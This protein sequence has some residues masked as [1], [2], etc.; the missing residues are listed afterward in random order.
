MPSRQCCMP[1]WRDD[2]FGLDAPADAT[3]VGC[4]QIP[5]PRSFLRRRP[6]VGGP[7]KRSKF[8]RS[9]RS[10]WGV[11]HVDSTIARLLDGSPERRIAA[12]RAGHHAPRDL[13]H[14]ML[15][16]P[17]PGGA[18]IHGVLMGLHQERR[19]IRRGGQS[20]RAAYLGEIPVVLARP[21]H[22][23]AACGAVPFLVWRLCATLRALHGPSP[24]L[25]QAR[26]WPAVPGLLAMGPGSPREF[27]DDSKRPG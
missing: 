24:R 17:A 19:R 9:G 7:G 26:A 11:F 20:L 23:H 16:T 8:D 18:L 6:A 12:A 13:A 22:V 2:P 21:V 27:Q 10:Y 25:R 3:Q 5:A 4:P 1:V 15:D 14:S